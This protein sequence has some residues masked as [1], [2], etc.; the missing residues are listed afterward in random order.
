MH[1]GA[2]EASKLTSTIKRLIHAND[3][4]YIVFAGRV[5]SPH[6]RSERVVR[7]GLIPR[8]DDLL[9]LKRRYGAVRTSEKEK[10]LFGLAEHSVGPSR[11]EE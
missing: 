11:P 1:L 9:S 8:P 3:F 7:G 5:E 10:I 2:V 6:A 4:F